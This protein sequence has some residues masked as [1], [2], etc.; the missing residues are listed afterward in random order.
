[1]TSRLVAAWLRMSPHTAGG[2][3]RRVFA[4]VNTRVE[5]TAKYARAM[6]L[7]AAPAR[8]LGRIGRDHVC[9][10]LGRAGAPGQLKNGL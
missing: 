1:M 9:R 10:R 5:L 6:G 8:T 2:R 7:P 4:S 3:L